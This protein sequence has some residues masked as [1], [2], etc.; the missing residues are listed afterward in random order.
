M[1]YQLF[2]K[3]PTGAYNL[4][5][6]VDSY[7]EAVDAYTILAKS[8]KLTDILMTTIVDLHVEYCAETGDYTV[9]GPPVEHDGD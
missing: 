5:S 2:T 8:W 7:E 9:M 1:K 4:T 6:T 3:T